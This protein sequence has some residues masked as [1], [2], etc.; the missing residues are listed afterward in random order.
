MAHGDAAV[1]EGSYA[2]DG[3]AFQPLG[4]TSGQ[5]RSFRTASC[6]VAPGDAGRETFQGRYAT[7]PKSR[8]HHQT[9]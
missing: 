9:G 5:D 4:V 8:G 1:V 6:G 7:R 2:D 3:R